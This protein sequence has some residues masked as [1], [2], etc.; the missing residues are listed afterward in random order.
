MTE[1]GGRGKGVFP[2]G[3]R[4]V[5]LAQGHSLYPWPETSPVR[6]RPFTS[7][8][9]PITENPYKGLPLAGEGLGCASC[10]LWPLPS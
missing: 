5:L 3:P 10:S 4:A 8:P 7:R 2:Q 1:A 6:L 9:L